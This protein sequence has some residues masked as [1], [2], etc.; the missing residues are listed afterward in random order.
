MLF[1][2]FTMKVVEFE[3][4]YIAGNLLIKTRDIKCILKE[5]KCITQDC[6]QKQVRNYT[7][8]G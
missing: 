7:E 2:F 8:E 3:V 5:L 4:R 1:F 6:I